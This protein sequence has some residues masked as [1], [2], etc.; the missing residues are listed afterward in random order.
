[1]ETDTYTKFVLTVIAVLLTIMVA[2]DLTASAAP[3]YRPIDVLGKVDQ[4]LGEVDQRA[5]QWISMPIAE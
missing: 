4:W 5:L 2:R 1:M 3:Q